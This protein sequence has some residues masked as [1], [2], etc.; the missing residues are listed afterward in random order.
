MAL[1]IWVTLVLV[2]L[3]VSAFFGNSEDVAGRSVPLAEA[4]SVFGADTC[5]TDSGGPGT[6][7]LAPCA[8]SGAGYGAFTLGVAGST[9]KGGSGDCPCGGTVNT[10]GSACK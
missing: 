2:G 7:G 9:T 5:E 10:A 1:R 4:A 6:C 8:L 3:T